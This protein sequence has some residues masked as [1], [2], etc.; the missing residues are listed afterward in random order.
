MNKN[1]NK[2]NERDRRTYFIYYI[3]WFIYIER[4]N[5]TSV[6]SGAGTGLHDSKSFYLNSRNVLSSYADT[7]QL[8]S[9]KY[10]WRT[11]RCIGC[12]I[13]SNRCEIQARRS[14]FCVFLFGVFSCEYFVRFFHLHHFLHYVMRFVKEDFVLL[15]YLK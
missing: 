10:E 6:F 4:L 14:F 7:V 2:M 8:V 9:T 12:E 15:Y 3:Y 11:R 5:T 13:T 1:G